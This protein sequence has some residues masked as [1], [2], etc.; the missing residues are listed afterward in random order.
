[1]NNAIYRP[2]GWGEGNELAELLKV[3]V[4]VVRRKKRD[5]TDAAIKKKG[6]ALSC[7]GGPRESISFT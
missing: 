3:C 6:E 4:V 2:D 5:G 1:M 7:G